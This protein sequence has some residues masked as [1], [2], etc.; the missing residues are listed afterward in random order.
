MELKEK[1]VCIKF[2]V[3][4]NDAEGFEMLKV[5][6]RERTMGKPLAFKKRPRESANK[7]NR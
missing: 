3:G 5:A 7:Q 2:F 6:V 4:K 1:C